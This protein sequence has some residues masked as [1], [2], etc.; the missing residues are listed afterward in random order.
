[1]KMIQEKLTYSGIFVNEEVE[2]TERSPR[3]TGQILRISLTLQSRG[4]VHLNAHADYIIYTNSCARINPE[5]IAFEPDT[6]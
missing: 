4:P 6:H 2:I 3:A 5:G 1:M